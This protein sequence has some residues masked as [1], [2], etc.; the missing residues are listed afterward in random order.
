MTAPL[1]PSRLRIAGGIGR[2]NIYCS[3]TQQLGLG[4]SASPE[5]LIV[6]QCQLLP[7]F[8]NENRKIVHM[9]LFY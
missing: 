5:H 9:D 2:I 7:N 3:C 8:T 1:D 6:I 4:F